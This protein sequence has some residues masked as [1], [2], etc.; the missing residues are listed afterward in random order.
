LRLEVLITDGKYISNLLPALTASKIFEKMRN[1]TNRN[2]FPKYLHKTRC[3]LE[4]SAKSIL[5]LDGFDPKNCI[6]ERCH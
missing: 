3:L 4:P 5:I 1:S 2:N 6:V